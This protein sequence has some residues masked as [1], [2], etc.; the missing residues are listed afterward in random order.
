MATAST[1]AIVGAIVFDDS[2][3]FAGNWKGQVDVYSMTRP[4]TLACSL[5][6][7]NGAIEALALNRLNIFSG[8]TDKT[9]K[10]WEI[11]RIPKSL[12]LAYAAQQA[13]AN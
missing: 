3:L 13:V 8:G 10:T 6:E 5:T 9:V 1:N 12:A 11:R 2:A 7:H 4:G